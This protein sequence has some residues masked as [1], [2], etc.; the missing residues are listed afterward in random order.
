VAEDIS[1]SLPSPE[2]SGWLKADYGYKIDREDPEIQS[3]V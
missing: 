1:I 3:K 2:E